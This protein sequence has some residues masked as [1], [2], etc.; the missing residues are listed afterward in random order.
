ML[1]TF[2]GREEITADVH[3]FYRIGVIISIDGALLTSFWNHFSAS[4]TFVILS[5]QTLK[6][7]L[8]D[9]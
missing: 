9:M 2:D 3:V 4:I 5:V 7:S 8:S 6:D 1:S